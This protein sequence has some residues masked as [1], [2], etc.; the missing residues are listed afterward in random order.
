MKSI[1]LAF[2]LVVAF[3]FGHQGIF[4]QE[5]TVQNTKEV[6]MT[7]AEKN[8]IRL[9]EAKKNLARE[10]EL[11]AIAKQGGI[12]NKSLSREEVKKQGGMPP[13]TP[14]EIKRKEAEIAETEEK[15]KQSEAELRKKGGNK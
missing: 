2:I 1:R 9:E 5:E 3:S 11:L 15:I 7:K 4:A 14:E 8:R 10:K 6:E 13:R 12:V